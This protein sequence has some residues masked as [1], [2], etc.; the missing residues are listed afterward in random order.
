MKDAHG[1]KIRE[2]YRDYA[3]PAYAYETV[4]R[5]LGGI[6][7]KYLAIEVADRDI[8]IIFDFRKFV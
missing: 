5:L 3:P 6:P 8:G 7:S 1:V 4:E 2:A